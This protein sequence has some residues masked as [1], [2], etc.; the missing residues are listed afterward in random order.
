MPYTIDHTNLEFFLSPGD[1]WKV[2]YED[3]LKATTSI[4]FE[5]YIL[6]NDELGR[7]FLQLFID[8][9]SQGVKV[10]LVL[11]RIGSQQHLRFAHHQGIHPRRRSHAFL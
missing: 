10:H 11:D 8:K 5:Q 7:R 2:M 9:A 3:C 4:D 1:T 6:A